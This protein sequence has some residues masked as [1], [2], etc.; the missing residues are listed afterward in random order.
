MLAKNYLAY[1]QGKITI[2]YRKVLVSHSE[3]LKKLIFIVPLTQYSIISMKGRTVLHT[4]LYDSKM[5]FQHF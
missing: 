2:L 3:L 1:F 4:K 5:I